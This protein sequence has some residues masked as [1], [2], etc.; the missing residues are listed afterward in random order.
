[1]ANTY[2]HGSNAGATD[3]SHMVGVA[4]AYA[5]DIDRDM[6]AMQIVSPVD[7]QGDTQFFYDL[8]DNYIELGVNS[9]AFRSIGGSAPVA[10]P[11]TYKTVQCIPSDLGH[12]V[13]IDDNDSRANAHPLGRDGLGVLQSTRKFQVDLERHV[14]G[15]LTASS[16]PWTVADNAASATWVTATTDVMSDVISQLNDWEA[17]NTLATPRPNVIHMGA[18]VARSLMLNTQ[19]VAQFGGNQ[20]AGGLSPAQIANA[21]ATLGLSLVVG[22]QAVY[23][24]YVNL[25]YVSSSPQIEPGGI[26]FGHTNPGMFQVSQIRVGHAVT[27]YYVRANARAVI[28]PEFG[29]RIT[30]AV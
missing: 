25:L 11:G 2:L 15:L 29:A 18:K 14:G 7:L 27:S 26:V 9:P 4:S 19:L 6:T 17:S 13:E 8:E 5:N 20:G 23:T 1:M 16:T 24:S 12:A 3:L 30:G 22:P 10:A 21:F 28:L